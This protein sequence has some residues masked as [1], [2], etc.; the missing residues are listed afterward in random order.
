M[1]GTAKS[2]AFWRERRGQN[3]D[4]QDA[5]RPPGANLRR[6]DAR[7]ER[8]SLR[9]TAVRQRIGYM[10]QKFSLYDDLT[11]EE[12]LDFFAGVYGVPEEELAKKSN[13]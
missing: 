7:G 3:D 1:F 2:M 6:D 11:I 10:S 5:M 13:G 8:G 9:S 12:N 4:H